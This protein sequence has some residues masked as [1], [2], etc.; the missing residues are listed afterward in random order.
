M[1]KR[2]IPATALSPSRRS[3]VAPFLAM[4]VLSQAALREAAGHNVI[5][6]E[7]G[8]PGAAPP[9]LVR[10]AAIAALSGGKVGY[11]ASLGRPSLRERIARHY[12]DLYGVKVDAGRIAVTT[13]SSAGFILAF[14][15][16]FDA[17]QRIAISAPGY[18]AYR[19]ILEALGLEAVLIETTAA[20]RH[21]VTGAMLAAE[22]A[23][24][25]LDGALLMSPVNPTGTMMSAEGLADICR[26]CAAL[27]IKFISDEIYHGLTYGAPAATALAFSADAV[28][29]N[30]FS[31]YFCMTGWRIG[32]L[33]LPPALVRPVERLQQS[34]AI[35]VPY[36]SQVAA[37]AA[38]D[39]REELEAVKAGYARNR[40]LLL[41]ELP[42]LGFSDFHPADGAF[43]FYVDIG[44]YSNDS[45]QFCRRML[46]EAGVAATPG[47][48]FDRMHGARAMR[49]SYAG[50]EADVREAVGR[51]RQWMKQGRVTLSL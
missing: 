36:L 31:K 37:E 32:W 25:K 46:D 49:L 17:G 11:T 9:R 18:P 48:D 51:L 2:D 5:H 14:L 29:V 23:R 22:H 6:M 27:G 3:A 16:M 24:Q 10:E 7:V 13:G 20:T 47:L 8:E 38:F 4:D 41:H 45:M 39:A 12:R 42:R 21:V 1:H 19:N 43:Y 50:S 34:L 28:V 15:A 26:T 40:D 35:S 33:V 30:S 44:R